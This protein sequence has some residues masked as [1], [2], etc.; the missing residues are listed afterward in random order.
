MR[1]TQKKY[2]IPSGSRPG[3]SPGPRGS[4]AGK[5]RPWAWAGAA[6]ARSFAFILYILEIFGNMLVYF[7]YIGTGG[8]CGSARYSE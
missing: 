5:G 1:E 4:R 7:L 8:L 2:K 3:P 6:A